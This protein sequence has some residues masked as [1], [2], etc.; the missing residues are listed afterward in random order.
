MLSNAP[1]NAYHEEACKNTATNS[2]AE[3]FADGVKQSG[4]T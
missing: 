4:N 1:L 2:A 3:V